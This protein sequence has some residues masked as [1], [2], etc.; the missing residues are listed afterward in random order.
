MARP[1]WHDAL[2]VP[3]H[4]LGRSWDR[5][6][7]I[8]ATINLAWVFFDL[9]Y[10]P[11]RT[12]WLQRNLYPI[13]SA[14]LALPLRFLPDV[15]PWMDPIKGIEPHRETQAYQRSF[16]ELDQAMLR[17]APPGAPLALAP[18]QIRLLRRQIRL[19]EQMIDTNPFEATGAS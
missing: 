12:F 13:P 9:S 6:V 18:D 15:T 4:Q 8:W 10:V 11:L 3:A 16:Q 14:P 7:A 5:F 1:R 19:N 17:P 2:P